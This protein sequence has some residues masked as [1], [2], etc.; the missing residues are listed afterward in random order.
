MELAHLPRVVHGQTSCSKIARMVETSRQRESTEVLW[1]YRSYCYVTKR[2]NGNKDS[3]A[4]DLTI[5]IICL[6]SMTRGTVHLLLLQT[7]LMLKW[8]ERYTYNIT[9]IS[10]HVSFIGYDKTS[11]IGRL[12]LSTDSCLCYSSRFSTQLCWRQVELLIYHDWSI[13]IW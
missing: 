11:S 13:D 9:I 12:W 4:I 6:S 1:C 10:T 7:Q 5:E 2:K 8:Y 3:L